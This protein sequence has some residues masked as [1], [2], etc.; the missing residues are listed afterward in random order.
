MVKNPPED[1]RD[2]VMASKL[3]KVSLIALEFVSPPLTTSNCKINMPESFNRSSL[4]DDVYRVGDYIPFLNQVSNGQ[5]D[6]EFIYTQDGG[7]TWFFF[8]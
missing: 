3:E 5:K 1:A 4:Y 6:I 7:Q 8:H 2:L